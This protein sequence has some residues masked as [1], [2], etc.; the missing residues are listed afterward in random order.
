MRVIAAV[1]GTKVGSIFTLASRTS[2][3]CFL[4]RLFGVTGQ[5]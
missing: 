4:M 5:N 3:D 1:I 2:L